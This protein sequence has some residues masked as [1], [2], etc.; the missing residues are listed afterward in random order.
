[1]SQEALLS[2]DNCAVPFTGV[3]NVAT[4][5][6]SGVT[7]NQLD[8]DLKTIC[9]NNDCTK[10]VTTYLQMCAVSCVFHTAMY[11]IATDTGSCVFKFDN[12]QLSKYS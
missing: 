1:M 12:N 7:V 4:G 9:G 10:A 5:T 2:A 8:Q 3:L 11:F 6:I